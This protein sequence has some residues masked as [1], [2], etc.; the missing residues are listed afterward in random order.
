MQSL[1]LMEPYYLLNN[2]WVY[3]NIWMILPFLISG[4]NRF[5]H[6]GR[7]LHHHLW[8]DYITRILMFVTWV[9]YLVD[10]WVKYHADGIGTLC[11]KA[12]F[13]HHIS[14]IFILPPLF[15]NKYVPWWVSPIGWMHGFLLF[16]P[17]IF[18]LNYLYVGLVFVFHYGLYQKPYCDLKGYWVVRFGINYINVFFILCLVD[19]CSNFLPLE[20]TPT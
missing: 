14:S 18:W 20:R 4:L 2:F 17:H 7:N 15:I 9:F 5:L 3:S 16:L 11:L 1:F 10:T 13:I 6:R 19:S 12:F 8:T